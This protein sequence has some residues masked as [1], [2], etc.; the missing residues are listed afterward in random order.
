MPRHVI[1]ALAALVVASAP[2]LPTLAAAPRTEREV[3]AAAVADEGA[4]AH[5]A[6]GHG[7]AEP[8]IL[9]PQPSLAIW[10]VIVFLGLLFLLGRFAWKPLLDT[11]HQRE[12]HLE[13]VLLDTERA[14]NEAEGLLSEHRKLMAEAQEKVRAMLETAR[15]EAQAVYDEI[16]RKAQADAEATQQRAEREIASARDQ[17]LLELWTKS[18]DLAVSVAGKV[19]SRDLGPDDHRRLVEA[20]MNELPAAPAIASSQGGVPA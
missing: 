5:A 17:A 9:E 15:H 11:L 6:T 1:L 7:S 16:T 18:A 19:L 3:A 20:A 4:A 8:N 2:G 12:E 14:R 10:T 13:H